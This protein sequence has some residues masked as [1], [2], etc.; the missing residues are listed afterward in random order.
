MVFIL[1]ASGTKSRQTHWNRGT[2][3]FVSENNDYSGDY[4]ESC[5]R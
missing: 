3:L 1:V 5:P 2:V 4:F